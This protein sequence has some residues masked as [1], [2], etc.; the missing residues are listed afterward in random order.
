VNEHFNII[1]SSAASFKILLLSISKFGS[2]LTS[3]SKT[4]FLP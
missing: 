3:E 4:N 1:F 2:E